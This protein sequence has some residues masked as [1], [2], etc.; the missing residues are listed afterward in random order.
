MDKNTGE[1]Y[2]NETAIIQYAQ[3]SADKTE[4]K[5]QT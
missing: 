4:L 1:K 5:T 3:T 2:A